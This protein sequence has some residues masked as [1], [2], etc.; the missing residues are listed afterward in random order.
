MIPMPYLT[1]QMWDLGL[2]F[3]DISLIHGLG[4]FLTFALAP[5]F[6]KLLTLFKQIT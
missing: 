5:I 4:P 3:E 6:G 1:L 2:S